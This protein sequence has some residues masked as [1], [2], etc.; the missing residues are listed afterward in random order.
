[1][2][3]LVKVLR[4]IILL[5]LLLHRILGQPK[6]MAQDLLAGSLVVRLLNGC[7]EPLLRITKVIEPGPGFAQQMPMFSSVIICILTASLIL[8]LHLQ[9]I[10]PFC[11]SDASG[12]QACPVHCKLLVCF[13]QG[14]HPGFPGASPFFDHF[15]Q[16]VS[17]D[18]AGH[19][20]THHTQQI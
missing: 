20:Q 19:T 11:L 15:N 8:L 13:V 16:A 12:Q 10:E 5:L 7:E 9:V 6:V 17:K 4:S 2:G 14:T 18:M 1:M 3:K